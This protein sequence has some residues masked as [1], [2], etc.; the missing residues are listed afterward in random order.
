MD[1]RM[2]AIAQQAVYGRKTTEETKNDPPAIVQ[3]LEQRKDWIA[4]QLQSIQQNTKGD[5]AGQTR[6]DNLQKQMDNIDKQIQTLTQQGGISASEPAEET[7]TSPS[8]FDE[9]IKSEERTATD[10]AGIYRLGKDSE[11]NPRILIDQ[12]EK[13]K[14]DVNAADIDTEAKPA[15]VPE[16]GDK[17]A[18]ASGEQDDLDAPPADQDD[19]DEKASDNSPSDK[20]GEMVTIVSS[21]QVDAELRKIREQKQQ[22][23]QEMRRATGDDTKRAKLEKRLESIE[24]E[25]QMKDN[26][27]YRRQHAQYTTSIKKND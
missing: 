1:L 7:K 21:D 25:L 8:Q 17:T 23:E 9:F 26:D 12:P 11:G 20:G 10:S 15:D 18:P 27:D 5:E 22:I 4:E 13:E 2:E 19:E 24:S 6:K 16:Q 14:A 3:R